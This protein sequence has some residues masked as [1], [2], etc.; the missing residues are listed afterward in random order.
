[1]DRV[2][3]I[4]YADDGLIFCDATAPQVGTL[5]ASL[6]CFESISSLK[7]NFHKSASFAVGE[8]PNV[9]ELAAI[10]GCKI[11]SCPTS[12]LGLPLG[13]KGFKES[14]WDPVLS[15]FEKRL[16]SWKTQFLSFGG[17]LV[18][19][20]SILSSLQVYFMSL[21]R[22]LTTV[23]VKLESIQKRFLWAGVSDKNHIH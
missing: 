15:S 18:L 22:A 20:K 13:A 2:N 7:L 1:M 14:L 10:F 6:I 3:H 16:E 4:F 8:V 9:Y 11:D 5:A 19:I 23:I 21:L 17:R 12:Y